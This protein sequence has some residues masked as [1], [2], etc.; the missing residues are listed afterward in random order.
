M[1][2][3]E[4]RSIAKENGVNPAKLRKAE[5]IHAI[6]VEEHND[7]CY[8]TG[9]VNECDQIDCLWRTDCEKAIS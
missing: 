3:T 2:M 4:I 5:L 9:Y 6:Q 1:N 8:A 7:P